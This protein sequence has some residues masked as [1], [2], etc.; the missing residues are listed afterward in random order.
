LL[1]R[2]LPSGIPTIS[3]LSLD[4]HRDLL[5]NRPV[6][7]GVTA[8]SA[9]RD[10]LVNPLKQNL[11]GVEVHAHAF[12]TIAEGRFLVPAS[13]TTVLLICVSLAIAAGR[14]GARIC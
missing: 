13:N 8:L 2:Y 14:A 4:Q 5:H 7:L 6:F 3:V 10:R 11:P 9:A 1:V 12:D